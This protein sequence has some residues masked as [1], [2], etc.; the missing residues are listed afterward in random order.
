MALLCLVG[1][2]NAK[3]AM[4]VDDPQLL[5]DLFRQLRVILY[6]RCGFGLVLEARHEA[7]PGI[8]AA[9]VGAKWASQSVW[10]LVSEAKV[11]VRR[12]VS[13]IG[14]SGNRTCSRDVWIAYQRSPIWPPA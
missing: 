4:T 7:I 12:H 5:F 10:V 14:T 2:A 1:A 6:L 9:N 13:P 8:G 3:N 11:I